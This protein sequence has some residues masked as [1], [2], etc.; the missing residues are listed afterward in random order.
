MATVS[1]T[2]TFRPGTR[3]FAY[4]IPD[5]TGPMK[6]R[7]AEPAGGAVADSS[8]SV[9][10]TVPVSPGLVMWVT[11]EPKDQMPPVV[12]RD[13]QDGVENPYSVRATAA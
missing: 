8:G 13:R 7:V 11:G 2:A 6:G 1:V 10:I 5:A 12:A 3:V 9:S 4:R